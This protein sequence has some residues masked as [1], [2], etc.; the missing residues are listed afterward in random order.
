MTA[1]AFSV[2]T[3]VILAADWL[4]MPGVVATL[5]YGQVLVANALT[6]IALAAFMKWSHEPGRY[7]GPGPAEP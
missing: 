1:L 6:G 5:G 2:L 4:A 3:V 7:G